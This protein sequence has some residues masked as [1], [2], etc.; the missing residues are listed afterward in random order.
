MTDQGCART[1]RTIRQSRGRNHDDNTHPVLS[2]L[3]QRRQD[4]VKRYMDGEPIERICQE[5]GCAKS[6]LYKWKKRY[7]FDK[8]D[9][10]QTRSRRP[11]TT[12][13]QTPE[14]LEAEIVRLYQTLTPDE[15]G[16]VSVQQ[17]RDHLA[18]HAGPS[19]PSIRTIYRILNRH[20]KEVRPHPIQS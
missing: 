9:W 6:W 5:M 12:P 15:S 3:E 20:A 4:A 7:R 17:I 2:A 16:T 1:S 13:T 18:Q 8:P 11:Q 10:S 14:A 19:S